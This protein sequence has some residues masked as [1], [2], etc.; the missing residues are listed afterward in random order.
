MPLCALC[1]HQQLSAAPPPIVTY[2][3]PNVY[4]Q[5]C[6]TYKFA[7]SCLEVNLLH[8]IIPIPSCFH[9]QCSRWTGQCSLWV[10]CRWRFKLDGKRAPIT[11]EWQR[12]WHK[13]EFAFDW[14]MP[15]AAICKAAA[16]EATKTAENSVY[17]PFLQTQPAP[18]LFP[19]SI[20][21]FWGFLPETY[22]ILGLIAV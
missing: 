9:W 21:A 2:P 6:T 11:A 17:C 8:S 5:L 18:H 12:F 4:A 14:P 20:T 22:C 10:V 1:C 16:I 19:L 7:L 13:P 15:L 3:L